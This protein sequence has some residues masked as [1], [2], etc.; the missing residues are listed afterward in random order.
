MSVRLEASVVAKCSPETAWRKFEKVE[1]WAWWNPVIARVQWIEGQP[2]QQG[3]TLRIDLARP[4]LHVTAKVLECMAPNSVHWSLHATGI[5]GDHWFT[6][7]PQTDGTT[8]LR[9]RQEL[10]GLATLFITRHRQ[11]E[12]RRALETWLNALKTEAEKMAREEAARGP[13]APGELVDTK[14]PQAQHTSSTENPH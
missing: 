9:G 1:F 10:K 3:S 4:R 6:F 7:E 14:A 5:H 8:V 11:E 13:A 2:W 12:G